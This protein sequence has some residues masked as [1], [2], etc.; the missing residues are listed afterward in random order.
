MAKLRATLFMLVLPAAAGACLVDA[1]ESS[2]RGLGDDAG[3]DSN[4]IECW[5]DG[6]MRTLKGLLHALDEVVADSPAKRVRVLRQVVASAKEL[7]HK[8]SDRE[9]SA[10]DSEIGT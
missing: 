7:S 5:G 6:E 2:S 10:L 3:C 4:S 8:L 1:T 9:R